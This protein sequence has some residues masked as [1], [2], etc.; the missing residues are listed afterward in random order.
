[1]LFNLFSAC[2]SH[3]WATLFA[4]GCIVVTLGHGIKY[5]NITTDPVQLWASPNSRS[6]LERTYFDEHF[7]PFYRTEQ[8]II[9]AVNLDNVSKFTI[10]F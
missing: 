5:L 4:G 2:A 1:M 9:N 10:I 6:R 7:E 8:V 3:P